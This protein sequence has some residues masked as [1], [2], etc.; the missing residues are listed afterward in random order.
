[1]MNIRVQCA[2]VWG[3]VLAEL[4][5]LGRGVR[6]PGRLLVAAVEIVVVLLNVT[7]LS[8]WWLRRRGRMIRRY[9]AAS[10]QPQV[11]VAAPHPA[12]ES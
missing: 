8:M 10:G 9:S 3:S 6:W 2:V 5:R 7:G 4:E 12:P 11:L 1:M